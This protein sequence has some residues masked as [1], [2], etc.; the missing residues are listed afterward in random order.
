MER[1]DGREREGQREGMEGGRDAVIQSHLLQ[2]PSLRLTEDQFI[3][4]IHFPFLPHYPK[5][6]R[7]YNRIKL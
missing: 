3:N 7:D 2:L 4:S 1:E 6:Q 5:R